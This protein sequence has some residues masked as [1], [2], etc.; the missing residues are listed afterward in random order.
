MY[1]WYWYADICYAFL[2]DVPMRPFAD[3]VWFT[4]GWT[5]QELLAPAVVEFYGRTWRRSGTKC[6]ML[7]DICD[8]TGIGRGYLLDRNTIQLVT[9]GKNFSWASRRQ[10]TRVEDI[11]YCQITGF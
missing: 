11:A 6:S 7:Q 4:R 10:T 3:S 1:Q 5:L 2:S 9:I 8:T